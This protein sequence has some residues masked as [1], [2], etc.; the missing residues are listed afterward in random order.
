MVNIAG[1]KCLLVWDF[2]LTATRREKRQRMKL[3]CSRVFVQY[4]Y[5]TPVDLTSLTHGNAHGNLICGDQQPLTV[6]S[7]TLDIIIWINLLFVVIL[8]CCFK[9]LLLVSPIIFFRYFLQMLSRYKR[10]EIIITIIAYFYQEIAIKWSLSQYYWTFFLFI[11]DK[12]V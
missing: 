2:N 10:T 9:I 5:M 8:K 4:I 12:L 1:I 11:S 7:G 3:N 6:I